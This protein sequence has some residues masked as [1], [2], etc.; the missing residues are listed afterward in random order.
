MFRQ[1]RVL[2]PV[3]LWQRLHVR[4]PAHAMCLKL[5]DY[6]RV[7]EPVSRIRRLRNF[8]R[9]QPFLPIRF[10]QQRSSLQKN[11]NLDVY[12]VTR[13]LHTYLVNSKK[14]KHEGLPSL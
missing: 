5:I 2:T 14:K 7:I 1:G 12:K 4:L 11:M 6:R 13:L 9:S 3:G 10:I 8:L